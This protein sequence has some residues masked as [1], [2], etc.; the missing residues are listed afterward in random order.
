[1]RIRTTEYDYGLR[2]WIEFDSKVEAI[3]VMNKLEE[4]IGER[5]SGDTDIAN[6]IH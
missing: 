4:L 2:Y 5:D 6:E 3:R 1:M